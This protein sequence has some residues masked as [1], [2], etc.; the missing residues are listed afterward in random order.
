MRGAPAGS[1]GDKRSTLLVVLGM[2]LVFLVALGVILY[3]ALAADSGTG[4][5]GGG[6]S[7]E[8][9]EVSG[10]LLRTAGSGPHIHFISRTPPESRQFSG[11]GLPPAG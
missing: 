8:A 4:G 7:E 11:T 5:E 9:G 10:V 3:F 6:D 1:A 2:G